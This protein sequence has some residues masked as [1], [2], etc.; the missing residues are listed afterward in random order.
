KG[1]A[2]EGHPANRWP[3]SPTA[4]NL[5]LRMS[6]LSPRW[7]STR[8]F[9]QQRAEARMR[10][11]TL[12]SPWKHS[13]RPGLTSQLVETTRTI[14]S[15]CRWVA[16]GL[17]SSHHEQQAYLGVVQHI[18]Q[19]VQ[20]IVAWEIGDGDGL[21]VEHPHESRVVAF[22]GHITAPGGIGRA[23]QE[24]GAFGNDGATVLV[25]VVDR[26]VHGAWARPAKAVTQLGLV[27]ITAV[28]GVVGNRAAS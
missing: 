4:N 6:P 28:K 27:G 17:V 10:S 16:R 18:G 9:W 7:R 13:W 2:R 15:G 21:V 3:R 25:Q 11:I 1:P 14:C 8:D 20:A 19:G 26:L 12:A 22:G 23:Q 24:E 5:G